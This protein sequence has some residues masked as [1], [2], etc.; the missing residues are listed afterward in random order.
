[1]GLIP[2]GLFKILLGHINYFNY[3]GMVLLVWFDK[4]IV[5]AK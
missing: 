4:L 2:V 5:N 1:M 3:G